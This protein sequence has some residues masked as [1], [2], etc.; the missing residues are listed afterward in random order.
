MQN[1]LILNLNSK[2]EYIDLCRKKSF[3]VQR[4]DIIFQYIKYYFVH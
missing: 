4:A 1:A 3:L 2:Q